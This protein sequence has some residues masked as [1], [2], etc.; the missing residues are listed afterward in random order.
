MDAHA[1]FH[2]TD[3]SAASF[4][5][6][7]DVV[8]DV[9]GATGGYIAELVDRPDGRSIRPLACTEDFAAIGSIPVT[10]S[11]TDLFRLMTAPIREARTVRIESGEL[12]A[13]FPDAPGASAFV[14]FASAHGENQNGVVGL[15]GDT[16]DLDADA[17][18]LLAETCGLLIASAAAARERREVAAI[19]ERRE[20][21]LEAVLGT[22]SIGILVLDR[23]GRLSTANV[24]ASGLFGRAPRDLVGRRIE[25]LVDLGDD[26]FL[27]WAAAGEPGGIRVVG[28]R[29][30]STFPLQLSSRL[31]EDH[32]TRIAV[33][34][35]LTSTEAANRELVAA[36]DRAEKA[37]A[38]KSRFLATMSHE[39]RTPLSGIIGMAE[40]LADGELGVEQ[41]E[42]VEAITYSCNA[43]LSMVNTV[44]D[45]SKL[46]AG[47]MSYANDPFDLVACVR[48]VVAVFHAVARREGLWLRSIVGP[49]V[50]LA[51]LGD[52]DRVRQVVMNLVGNA[53][54][55]TPE[56]GITIVVDSVDGDVHIRVV[57]TGVGIAPEDMDV[58]FDEFTQVG[59]GPGSVAGSGL[60]LAICRR[61]A[62]GMGG[63]IDAR[64]E[65]DA[66]S[67]FRLV[68][69]L[70][71]A[72]M[73]TIDEAPS[74]M[75]LALHPAEEVRSRIAR[76]LRLIGANVITVADPSAASA[77]LREGAAFETVITGPDTLDAVRGADV[78][79]VEVHDHPVDLLERS[80]LGVSVV[81]GPD[82]DRGRLRR[83]VLGTGTPAPPTRSL[84]RPVRRPAVRST[85]D[86]LEIDLGLVVDFFEDEEVAVHFLSDFRDHSRTRL[87][88]LEG[89]PAP[90]TV[91]TVAHQIRDVSSMLGAVGVAELAAELDTPIDPAHGW[92]DAADR[93]RTAIGRMLAS[94]EETLRTLAP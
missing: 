63:S 4:H 61:I 53:V 28:R 11:G 38:A 5:D 59:T 9:S 80:N 87:S 51:V 27:D 49:D 46:E 72:E 65:V 19:L 17:T 40:L 43:L 37:D 13:R 84:R 92:A 42:F 22:T 31:L 82:L 74:G 47:R 86:R 45:F 14:G 75:I 93:L 41:R 88:E 23:H 89:E 21:M 26:R 30:G 2:G 24:A 69:P 62:D 32:E 36:R 1:A 44:L 52:S 16:L 29:P 94:I 79:I 57:D 68:L 18:A 39:I 10:D 35:D 83:A 8:L 67:E 71:P 78:R 90:E 34:S 55:F 7:L 12:A 6:L 25:D 33:L 58:I 48:D 20:H 81:L 76:E 66:G 91:R 54:K 3:G 60:G 70:V 85:S 15:S 50:P 73:D 64:S 77:M 56:G